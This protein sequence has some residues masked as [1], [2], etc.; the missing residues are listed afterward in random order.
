ML[1]P[2]ILKSDF[3]CKRLDETADVVIDAIKKYDADVNAT[4]LKAVYSSQMLKILVVMGV[5]VGEDI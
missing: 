3:V 2:E 1:L 5:D 4:S